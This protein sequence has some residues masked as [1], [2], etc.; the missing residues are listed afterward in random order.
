MHL[1]Y[2]KKIFFYFFL[3]FLVFTTI[4]V[5]V[6]RNREKVYKTENLRTNLDT[7]T[8]IIH[9]YIRQKQMRPDTGLDTLSKILPLLPD[10]LRLTIIDEKGKVLFDNTIPEERE[11]ENHLHRPE[12]ASALIHDNGSAI[13]FS[14]TQ[15]KEYYYYAY[16]HSPYY[17][18]VAL[19]Y[20]VKLKDY[21]EGDNIFM[22]FI[23]LL[24]FIA[25]I[26]LLYLADRFGKAI[27]GLN[28]FITSAENNQPAYE[29]IH[30]PDTE[31]G[32]IGNKIIS[33]FKLLEESKNQL[34]QEKEKLLRH[35]HYSEEGI[36]IFSADG[37]KIYANTHFIQYLNIILDEPTFEVNT[38]L[39]KPDFKDLRIFLKKNTPVNPQ[40]T[41][42]PIYQGK[43]SKSGKHFAVKL[44]V[45]KDNSFEVTLNN[46]SNSEKNRLLK[47]EMTNN[48]AH[49]LKTPVSSIRG[50]IET[51]L[52]QPGIA[53]EKQKFFLER[54]YTQVLRLSDLIRDVALITKTEEAA[55]LFDKECVNIHDTIEEVTTDLQ[56]Q[57]Q[58]NHIQVFNNVDESVEIEGNHTLLYSIFRNL[59]D[60]AI[61]YAGEKITIGIDNYTEDVEYYY[62]SLYDTGCGV[63]ETHLERIF[64]R[65]YRIN[66]GRSRKNGGSGLGLSIVKNA[67]LFHKGQIS[68]KN[69]KDGGLEFIFSLR[70]K[71]Y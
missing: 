62:F 51:L 67:V 40:S 16:H 29:K 56:N 5:L 57:I 65:F 61:S 43:I 39:E 2:K 19:P 10:S 53:P 52:D 49:E 34:R 13:R 37:Q 71:L 27:S 8:Q 46:I 60:N 59:M 17:I 33:N 50:Y 32:V 22:Y 25:L 58:S 66:E 15:G 9:N 36:C 48:I 47:Q 14:T 23:V 70:K 26:S 11:I 30:F 28:D 18:R 45:F 21:L 20:N 54:T 38:I 31:L 1:S 35:F 55:D 44:I 42:Q 64:D 3:V 24:F 69:R 4:I 7:Y 6:Q 41:A 63:A 12:I 68:A